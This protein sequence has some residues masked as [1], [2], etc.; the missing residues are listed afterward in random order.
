MRM[1]FDRKSK[2]NDEL[3][4][5]RSNAC[6]M[7]GRH[8]DSQFLSV[9]KHNKATK[10]SEPVS[11]RSTTSPGDV[12]SETT[13]SATRWNLCVHKTWKNL[14]NL[15]E[16]PAALEGGRLSEH[17]YPPRSAR[18]PQAHRAS[19]RACRLCWAAQWRQKTHRHLRH[20]GA[21]LGPRLQRT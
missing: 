19:D 21:A 5:L 7:L 13:A 3:P 20:P 9:A 17:A 16:T 15:F 14:T 6:T 11:T 10:T 1:L 12:P 2:K 4:A 18:T 8:K